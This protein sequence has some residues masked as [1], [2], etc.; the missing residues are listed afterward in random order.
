MNTHRRTRA[1]LC[2][3][4]LIICALTA[5][6]RQAD[7][8]A[9]S[10]SVDK[11]NATPEQ[12]IDDILRAHGISSRSGATGG[13]GAHIVTGAYLTQEDFSNG[14]YDEH[15]VIDTSPGI[16]GVGPTTQE[17][18]AFAWNGGI[19]TNGAARRGFKEDWNVYRLWVTV[20]RPDWIV[21]AMVGSVDDD[22][23]LILDAEGGSFFHSTT[24]VATSVPID[25]LR[26][27]TGNIGD[28]VYRFGFDS[29]MT[30]GHASNGPQLL[31]IDPF[32]Q[33]SSFE[34]A[35]GGGIDQRNF[36]IAHYPPNDPMIGVPDPFGTYR[37]LVGQFAVRK[38]FTFSGQARFGGYGANYFLTWSTANGTMNSAPLALVPLGDANVSMRNGT[39]M[40]SNVGAS[41]LDG[42]GVNFD[43]AGTQ[44]LEDGYGV[45]VQSVDLAAAGTGAA[46]IAQC[47]L[48]NCFSTLFDP[49]VVVENQNALG[50]VIG[51]AN[52]PMCDSANIEVWNNGTFQGMWTVPDGN[53]FE[54]TDT[55]PGSASSPDEVTCIGTEL[56]LAFNQSR[57]LR[58]I[59]TDTL[60]NADDIRLTPADC[61]QTFLADDDG[62]PVVRQLSVRMKNIPE[63]GATEGTFD[64]MCV[65]D[66]APPGGNG[67]RDI[68][69]FIAIANAFGSCNMCPEDIKPVNHPNGDVNI[70]DLVLVL[71][72][73]G[74]CP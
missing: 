48:A 2:A 42:M 69:D 20:T 38:G 72:G 66:I 46:F 15:G 41:G 54:I 51:T 53:L 43:S 47:A 68:D 24:G 60:V 63:F 8:A 21:L 57:V 44:V 36:G 11:T 56:R 4:S 52:F 17:K 10:Y 25:A 65:G 28:D 23:R 39:V 5:N 61:N 30:L 35:C 12:T 71:N 59:V 9:P 45:N 1:V 67:V 18:T 70:D 34:N 13:G 73:F 40:V 7:D 50:L 64:P 32:D 26:V 22:I 55:G 49:F 74:P 14:W 27:W 58:I 37:I 19:D 29:F 31:V 3:T 62:P 6:A 16:G 33:Q